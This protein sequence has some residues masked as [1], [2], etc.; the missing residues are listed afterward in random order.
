MNE[1]EA[2][3]KGG[4]RALGALID[5]VG[6]PDEVAR[7][8][9]DFGLNQVSARARARARG[10]ALTALHTSTWRW[11]RNGGVR[12]DA[13]MRI[14]AVDERRAAAVPDR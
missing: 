11:R 6:A 14:G 3:F 12:A 7:A 9:N 13:V 5:N 4:D 1:L 10:T 8:S 2:A